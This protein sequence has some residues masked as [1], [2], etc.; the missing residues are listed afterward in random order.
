MLTDR[1]PLCAVR[2]AGRRLLLWSEEEGKFI[3]LG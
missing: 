3:I 2:A 1:V